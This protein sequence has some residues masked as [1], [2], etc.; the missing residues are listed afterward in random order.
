M[1]SHFG[2]LLVA[3]GLD[4]KSNLRRPAVGA[5]VDV[6]V[7]V[8]AGRQAVEVV[9]VGQQRDHV[10]FDLVLDAAGAVR[11]VVP[12][13]QDVQHRPVPRQVDAVPPLGLGG[14][15]LEFSPG[16]LEQL[17]PGQEGSLLSFKLVLPNYP[18]KKT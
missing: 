9:R 18:G 17:V 6:E 3:A 15:E 11:H 8:G 10:A 1:R 16:Q 5:V 7:Q 14:P 12:L 2:K 4:A 13:G